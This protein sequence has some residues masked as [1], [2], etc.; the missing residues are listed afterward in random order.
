[1]F[2]LR[3]LAN[4]VALSST[5]RIHWPVTKYFDTIWSEV[6]GVGAD[7]PI[8]FYSLTDDHNYHLHKFS[9]NLIDELQDVLD[10]ARIKELL[11]GQTIYC[12]ELA[13]AEDFNLPLYANIGHELGHAVVAASRRE[14]IAHLDQ[15]ASP[16]LTATKAGVESLS[17]DSEAKGRVT[18]SAAKI[19]ITIAEELFCDRIASQLVGPAYLLSL[20]EISWGQ[21][22]TAMMLRLPA[23]RTGHAKTSDIHAYP[24]FNFRI[25]LASRWTQA[26][27]F[28]HELA[29]GCAQFGDQAICSTL[30]KLRTLQIDHSTDHCPGFALTL[31]VKAIQDIISSNMDVLKACVEKAVES[32]ELSSTDRWKI[33]HH[34][35]I[36]SDVVA[37]IDRLNHNIV[38]N[39][40]PDNTLLGQP[41]SFHAILNASAVYR[42]HHLLGR[43]L[44]DLD[45]FQEK[46]DILERLTSKALEVTF[47]Q[48]IFSVWKE[49][50]DK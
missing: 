23:T 12:L 47:I 28:F 14:F 46:V 10:E 22:L 50:V 39:I 9:L 27:A 24:S 19:F 44:E 16:F 42:L 33:P 11:A 29:E 15:H 4:Q 32:F 45:V 18:R 1:V 8:V 25:A 38:P 2:F 40:V 17:L 21:D 35:C 37:L 48:R 49:G 30:E 43:A 31:E 20:Y 41:A 3:K 34:K 5:T 6:F 13:S 36:V 7:R 26:D